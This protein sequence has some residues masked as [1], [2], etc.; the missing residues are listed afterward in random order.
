[1]LADTYALQPLYGTLAPREAFPKA[2]DAATTALAIENRL[3]EAHTTLAY[4]RFLYEWRW[5]MAE[6]AFR[7]AIQLNPAYATGHHWYA[8]FLSSRGRFDEAIAEIETAVRLDPLSLV[9]NADLGMVLYFAGRI[10]RALAQFDR[11]DE[12]D[13]RF[14]YGYFGRALALEAAGRLDQA[15]AA[16]ARAVDLSGRSSVML[17]TYGR[18]AAVDGRTGEARAIL[19]E[20]T[21]RAG[22]EY[23]SAAHPAMVQT[24]LGD[25]EATLDWWERAAEERSRFVPF[26]GV[27]PIFER[28]VGEP[29]FERLI[30]AIGPVSGRNRPPARPGREPA[31]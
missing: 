27:W 16:A 28:L 6:E 30:D 10:E 26:C 1:G 3:A 22:E 24:G 2:I 18:L 9:I 4:S 25:V 23:V 8:Y 17:G 29:R 11:A 12:L 14:A 15:V 31:G 5:E 7:R 21:A 13:P 19:A 20:L